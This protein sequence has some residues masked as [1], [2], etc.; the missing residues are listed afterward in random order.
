MPALSVPTISS[1]ALRKLAAG[2][3]RPASSRGRSSPRRA[4]TSPRS[5]IRTVAY[6]S[7]RCTRRGTRPRARAPRRERRV[8]ER[9]AP[10]DYGLVGFVAMNSATLGEALGARRALP[11][12]LDRRAGDGAARRRHARDRLPHALRRRPGAA[13][14]DRGRARRVC[15]RRAAPPQ[16]QI[17]PR[18]VRF[19]HP[20]PPTPPR[21]RRSSAARCASAP[22]PAHGAAHE[23]L[24]LPLPQADAQLGAFL[25][26][27]RTR[28]WRSGRARRV[29]P[30]PVREIIAEELQK[31][32]P[33]LARVA[34][35]MATSERTLRRGSKRAGRRSAMLLDETRAE[36]A[37]SY[38]RDAGMPL[39]EVAFLLG[40][41]EPSAFHRAFSRWTGTTPTAFRREA[42]QT[43]PG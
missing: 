11:R 4:W 17:V 43:H 14:R 27:S 29:A 36:L 31:G 1:G 26:T 39:S 25:R 6:R 8:A 41:S 21:T 15:P 3:R 40:F 18:E 13:P 5:R 33:T 20:A 19:R 30:L 34:R 10:G 38:V 42:A 2:G 32:V 12:A 37:R 9:Y 23:D 28:R 16:T 7:R 24:A 22:R 35:R